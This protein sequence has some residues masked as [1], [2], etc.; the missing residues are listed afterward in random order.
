MDST[1][2][3]NID[4]DN[5]EFQNAWQLIIKSHQSVFL[6][7][8]AGTGKST[9]LRY[10]CENTTKKF[11]ILAPTGI[12]AV[13]VGG[14]TLHS[15]FKMP[16]KPLLKDDPEF[17][18]AEIKKTLKYPREKVK[19]IKE[20]ELIIIDEISMVRADMIDF[21]DKVLKVYSG[22]MREPFGGKQLLLVGDI[23]QLEPVITGDMRDILRRYY[24]QFFFFNANAFSTINLVPI[25]LQKIY[26]QNNQ[27]F[28]SLLDRIRIN[29]ITRNDIEAINSRF[30]PNY[31]ENKDEFVITLATRRDTVDVINEEQLKELTTP[32]YKYMG[33]IKDAFPTQNL[34]TSLELTV[35]VGAQVIFI[36]NDKEQ[37]WVNGTLG[38]VYHANKNEI[39]IELEN[40]SIHT[41][42]P[43]VWENVQYSYDEKEKK[44]TQK[45]LGTFQQFPIKPAW[46][47]TVHKS[48]GLTFSKV[49]IDFAGG[50]FTGGQ[51]YVALSR[52]TNLEGIILRQPLHGKDIFVNPGIIEFSKNFNNNEI[53]SDALY[54]AEANAGY[55]NAAKAFDNFD[56]DNAVKSFSKAVSMHNELSN[57][58]VQRLIRKKLNV[59]AS[60]ST[61]VNLLKETIHNQNLV[62][63]KL[64][65]EYAL[66]GEDSLTYVTENVVNE[67][68]AGYGNS[69]KIDRMVVKAAMANFD[70]ALSLDAQCMKALIGKGNLYL[71]LEVYDEALKCFEAIYQL[72]RNSIVANYNIGL[73]FIAL[74]KYPEAL[75]SLKRALKSNKNE[76]LTHDALAVV[77]DKI[78]LEELSG[79]HETIANKLRSKN[80]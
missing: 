68:V 44:I 41:L 77:Y 14:V 42:A 76:P 15:F 21:I 58:I 52:C 31:K 70:K 63:T 35:K 2:P 50:A 19:I 5:P 60:L 56:L 4:L 25:E 54:R 66:M 64:A 6:T 18:T 61:H 78:G 17:S 3:Q 9:F 38:R 51:T 48:Q 24:N 57:P 55:L 62:F 32:E 8:K 39:E 37:R 40:G 49:I 33:V 13:N 67:E 80:K 30:V 26:R 16:L 45:I 22:N 43:E 69:G 73:I 1:L 72:D 79:K 46:A 59:I 20:L 11:V 71:K 29:K 27:I 36:K 28:I 65:N 53:I 47:L 23:F 7:G 34:P 74:R 75:K 10:I 12:S